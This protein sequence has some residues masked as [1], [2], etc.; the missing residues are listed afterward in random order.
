MPAGFKATPIGERRHKFR[1]DQDTAT[2]RGTDGHIVPT[3]VRK[4]ER[5]AKII[6]RGSKEF[7][8][9]D[10]IAAEATHLLNIRYLAGLTSKMRCTLIGTTR[11]FNIAGVEDVRELHIEQNIAVT[12]VR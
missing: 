1:I 6:Q 5:W 8:E 10:R 12:E 4:D 11:T 2:T 9:G 3:W 7:P